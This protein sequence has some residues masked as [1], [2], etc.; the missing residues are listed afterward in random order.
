M[1]IYDIVSSIKRILKDQ[2]EIFQKDI[3]KGNSPS[4]LH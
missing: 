2:G 4:K 3:K 1:Q